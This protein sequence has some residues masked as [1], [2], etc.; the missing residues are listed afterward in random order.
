MAV[1]IAGLCFRYAASQYY[2]VVAHNYEGCITG[3]MP[4]SH[5]ST[6][7]ST[8]NP[9]PAACRIYSNHP[10]V[11]NRCWFEAAFSIGYRFV[12]RLHGT[13]I[14]QTDL[15]RQLSMYVLAKVDRILLP[16]VFL[17]TFPPSFS[18]DRHSGIA[19][20]YLF[21]NANGLL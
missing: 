4:H 17:S 16:S 13:H 12:F 3:L 6:D 7:A 21:H 15:C 11:E 19:R 14:R 20:P 10:H 9:C 1:K 18:L 5:Q 2:A 8:A